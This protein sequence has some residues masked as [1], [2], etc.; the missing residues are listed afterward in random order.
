MAE[1]SGSTARG[2]AAAAAKTRGRKVVG[3]KAIGRIEKS[4]DG[5]ELALKDLRKELGRGGRDLVKDL[6]TTLKDSRKNLRSL[7]RTVARDVGKVQ[8]AATRGTPP[9]RARRSTSGKGAARRTT[10]RRSTTGGGSRRTS[11]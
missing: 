11:R 10:G 1:R 6:E 9:T 4:I 8:R 5:A 3:P 2:R 7:S